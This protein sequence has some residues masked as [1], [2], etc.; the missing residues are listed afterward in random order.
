[1]RLQVNEPAGS[2]R[3]KVPR[4]RLLPILCWQVAVC[5]A[6]SWC[7]G[8]AREACGAADGS[9]NQFESKTAGV[10]SAGFCSTTQPNGARQ[11]ENQLS[12]ACAAVTARQA[13][14]CPQERAGYRERLEA[15]LKR[16][17]SPAPAELPIAAEEFLQ[18]YVEIAQD[19]TLGSVEKRGLL[20]RL[21]V[22][23]GRL[24]DALRRQVVAGGPSPSGGDLSTAGADK[25]AERA[26]APSGGSAAEATTSAT[27]LPSAFGGRALPD[28][29]AEELIELIQTVVRPETWETNGGRGRIFYW[30]PGQALIIRQ[31]DEVHREVAQLLEL[32]RRV[33]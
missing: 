3:Q 33:Q 22:R 20:R 16:W 10:R 9:A 5:L 24:K 31:T 11:A 17:L 29:Y 18:L 32:L 13:D 19:T 26:S 1:M 21:E 8:A 7:Q 2:Y 25:R 12:L 6:V 23:L 14:T 28:Q 4:K 27:A 30:P 15:A